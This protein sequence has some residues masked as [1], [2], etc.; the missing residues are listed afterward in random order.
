MPADATTPGSPVVPTEQTKP[1][2]ASDTSTK[3]GNDSGEDSDDF[4]ESETGSPNLGRS[5]SERF[6]LFS[7]LFDETQ[8][9]MDKAQ[10]ETSAAAA[11]KRNN[12]PLEL[13]GRTQGI[14]TDEI[15]QSLD[16]PDR[17]QTAIPPQDASRTKAAKEKDLRNLA[18]RPGLDR[19]TQCHHAGHSVIACPWCKKCQTYGHHESSCT[20]CYQC[21]SD[22]CKEICVKCHG[23]H[24][25]NFICPLAQ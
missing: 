23:A 1:Q 13:P 7:L 24:T 21:Q 22:R 8:E 10:R 12:T 16:T 17:P 25:H 20:K 5:G 9:F 3:V 6:S 19:C 14:A 11:R 18:Q 4:V 2:A 15:T